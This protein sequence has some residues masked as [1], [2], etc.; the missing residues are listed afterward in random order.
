MKI[1]KLTT[2]S[3]KVFNLTVENYE[4]KTHRRVPYY[5]IEKGEPV[6]YAVCPG[7][8]NPIKM[9]NLYDE[10]IINEDKTPQSLHARHRKGNVPN[11]AVYS[12]EQYDNCPLRKKN[13]FGSK[14]KEP[15][16]EI[17]NNIFKLVL[18]YPDILHR[19]VKDI[20]NINF[21]VRQFILMIIK[22]IEEKGYHYQCI[23]EFN[24]PYGF[25]YMQHSMRIINQYVKKENEQKFPLTK[26]INKSAYFKINN[27]QILKLDS[28]KY[29]EISCYFTKHR[30][31]KYLNET[32]E[33]RITE[34]KDKKTKILLEET[35]QISQTKY[36]ND[37]N[38][39]KQ[40][41]KKHHKNDKRDILKNE[42]QKILLQK[43]LL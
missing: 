10:K 20:T 14:V 26:S 17:R 7:C 24:L 9:V 31:T 16:Q 19:H 34:S 6:Y 36:I 4:D 41:E 38:N 32:V 1:F 2:E 5:A 33:F 43:N 8:N 3:T 23:N 22:F 39:A 37:I 28:V 35:L 12:Q 18:D 21:S 11:I 42:I 15:N 29:A 25:I 13:L 30:K 27:N 40:E